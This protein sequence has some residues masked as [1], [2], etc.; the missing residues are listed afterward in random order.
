LENILD[1]K[2]NASGEGSMLRCYSI[3][4]TNHSFRPTNNHC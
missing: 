3:K 2:E 4:L 1:T